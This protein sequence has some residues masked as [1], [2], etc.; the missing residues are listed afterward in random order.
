[1]QAEPRGSTVSLYRDR[2][3][4]GVGI[5]VLTHC[6]CRSTTLPQAL[7]ECAAAVV[8]CFPFIT[9]ARRRVC[10]TC[11]VWCR[12]WLYPAVPPPRE[13][14]LF[15]FLEN[16]VMVCVCHSAQLLFLLC[17]FTAGAGCTLPHRHRVSTSCFCDRNMVW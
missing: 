3:A 14:Q 4:D 8:S 15:L 1:V 12:S 7:F 6:M 2:R 11:F 13:Y 17:Q 5:A 16:G 10:R 9:N